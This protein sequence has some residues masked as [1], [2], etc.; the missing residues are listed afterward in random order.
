M[1]LT[2]KFGQ[3][4]RNR[5]NPYSGRRENGGIPVVRT[6]NSKAKPSPFVAPQI[7]RRPQAS[8][9][10]KRPPLP[11]PVEKSASAEERYQTEQ[12]PQTLPLPK[13]ILSMDMALASLWRYRGMAAVIVL[14]CMCAGIVGIT[15]LSKKYSAEI[16]IYFDPHAIELAQTNPQA[17]PMGPE[18]ISATIDSQTQILTSR[19]ILKRV[20]KKLD[21]AKDPEFA[22]TDEPTAGPDDVP[23]SVIEKLATTAKSKREQNSY[24]VTLTITTKGASKSADIANSIVE[25]F[26]DEEQMSLNGLYT[27]ANTSLGNRVAELAEEVR[28][29][30]QAVEDYKSKNDLVTADG[31]LISDKRLIA[32]NDSLLT[33][34]NRTIQAKARVDFVA[35][36]GLEATGNEKDAMESTSNELSNLRRQYS[37]QAAKVGSLQSQLGSRHPI[38]LA[39]K[40]S[41]GDIANLVKAEQDRILVK[42]KAQL[43]QAQQ[44]ENDVSKQLTLQKALQSGSASR[45]V[46]LKELQRLADTARAQYDAVVKRANDTGEKT[47]NS[48]N[49]IRVISDA[50]APAK[51]DGPA[52]SVMM[53]AGGFGGF[54][55]GMVLATIMSLVMAFSAS[56]QSKRRAPPSA[57]SVP[58]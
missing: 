56:A 14:I 31:N 46:G 29:A 25:E 54:M 50:A 21:L 2:D 49:N 55:L 57:R 36:L 53:I 20:A 9:V 18:A 43:Q 23:F 11:T 7:A 35:S 17:P 58:A 6:S 26:I 30:D 16:S 44:A 48:Y 8:P 10:L 13:P 39:A 5:R 51:A 27:N 37:E 19:V 3:S 33:A 47:N 40:A 15:T 4:P 1:S 42:A 41:M 38:L 24:V 12:E 28:K 32:L 45:L 22:S 34:Q 52:K